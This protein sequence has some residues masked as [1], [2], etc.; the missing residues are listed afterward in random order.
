MKTE[1]LTPVDESKEQKC[2]E[3]HTRSKIGFGIGVV[4]IGIILLTNTIY[5]HFFQMQFVWPIVIILIGLK[6]IFKPKNHHSSC[7][8]KR[9]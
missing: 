7:Y 3:N 9:G 5:P 1:D 8:K 6:L 4:S 2:Q